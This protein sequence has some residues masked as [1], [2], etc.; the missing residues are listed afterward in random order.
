MITSVK[1]LIIIE[2]SGRDGMPKPIRFHNETE[3]GV[4]TLTF[5]HPETRNALDR[6]TR[7]RFVDDLREA[8]E[9]PDI[10]VIVITGTDPA[11]T[12]GVDA[13]QLLD[14][15]YTPLRVDPATALRALSTP[16]VAAVNGSCVSGGLEIALACSLIIAS[17]NARF[18]DTH[19]KLG[20]SPGWGLSVELP[21]AIGIRRARQ[22]TLTAQPIDAQRAYEWGLVNEVVPHGEL[23]DRVRAIAAAVSVIDAR[24]A[25]NAVRLY[26][27]GHES[28]WGAS[29]DIE[30]D[31]LATWTV[32]RAAA[33]TAFAQRVSPPST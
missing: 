26:R 21:S 15:D 9:S 23:H 1:Y 24:S 30:R 32:D 33:R 17:T 12:S 13:K 28:V 19:A 4:L 11:F 5:D 31:A 16:T 8:D 20:L 2:I 10:R 25:T 18:A 14:P 27:D 7:E 22:L 29:R 6:D 3:D